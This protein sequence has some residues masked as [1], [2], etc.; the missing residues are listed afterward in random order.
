MYYSLLWSQH[1]L[2]FLL[3]AIRSLQALVGSANYKAANTIYIPE[4]RSPPF[5]FHHPFPLNREAQQKQLHLALMLKKKKGFCACL[6]GQKTP[7]YAALVVANMHSFGYM[8]QNNPPYL[9]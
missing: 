4:E 9:K 2:C 6:V 7:S 3:S 5:Y 1:S 8:H